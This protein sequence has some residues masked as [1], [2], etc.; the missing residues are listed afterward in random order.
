MAA[1]DAIVKAFEVALEYARQRES[2]GQPIFNHQAVGFRLA[3]CATRIE[4][5][6]QLIWH[7]AAL[8]DAAAIVGRLL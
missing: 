6:R 3:E 2:F 8:R 7:A 4:A 5:A 1:G